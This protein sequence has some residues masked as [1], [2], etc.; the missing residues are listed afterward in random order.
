MAYIDY[1]YTMH[2]ILTD[3]CTYVVTFRTL[4]VMYLLKAVIL[5]VYLC[6]LMRVKLAGM[7]LDE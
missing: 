3:F 1:A 2:T 7:P 5:N 6:V 4:R